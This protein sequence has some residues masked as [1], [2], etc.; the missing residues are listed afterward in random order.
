MESGE[1][2]VVGV[3]K[4]TTTEPNPLLADLDTAI[5]TVDPAVEHAAIEALRAWRAGR[6]AAAVDEALRALRDAAKTDDNL[7]AATLRC[8]RAGVTTGEWAGALREVFGEYRAPTGR[9]PPRLPKAE[10]AAEIAA[11]RDA[12][13]GETGEA[14]GRRLKMLVGKPGL[15]GHSNGAEQIAVRARDVGFEVIYQGIRLTPAQIV[16]AASRRTSTSSACRS[17]PARTW[18]SSRTCCAGC[19]TPGSTTCRSW[20][21]GSCPTATPG[22][23]ASWASPRSSRPRT[24][25]SPR[26]CRASSTSS[27]ERTGLP[28]LH[29]GAAPAA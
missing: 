7:M 24:S 10:R 13:S 22:G 18:S 25:A 2:V 16:A 17:C 1:D 15:D 8:A 14:L 3:N 5:Q 27:G 19:R 28:E 26:S 6:D 20:S 4:F 9:R 29:A 12:R 23:C 11:V 21:A